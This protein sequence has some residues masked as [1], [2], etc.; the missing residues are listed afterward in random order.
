MKRLHCIVEG[1]TEV[2]VFTSLLTPYILEK[3]GA[4]CLFTPVKHTG[5]GIVKFSKILPELRE[6]LKEKKI[7]ATYFDYYGI[8]ENHNFRNYHEAKVNQTNAKIGVELLE[9]G[10][11]EALVEKGINTRYFIP[12]IQLHEFEALLFSSTKSFE[13]VYD[14]DNITEEIQKINSRYPNPED[15]N[16]SPNTAP[17]KRI[18]KIVEKHRTS[19]EKVIDGEDLATLTSIDTIMEKCPRFKKWIT[20]IVVELN[21]L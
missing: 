7:V 13:L 5:G 1:Q 16:D 17:S 8:H 10:M 14:N 20:K 4:Y 6:H 15:I 21:N 19:Y 2:A 3:T 12:Y 9:K 11:F 18:I